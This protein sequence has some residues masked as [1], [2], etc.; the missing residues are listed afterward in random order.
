MSRL[1]NRWWETRPTRTQRYQGNG[2][3]KKNQSRR[4][5]VEVEPERLEKSRAENAEASPVRGRREEMGGR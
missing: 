2:A 3:G 4:T 5:A 1:Q